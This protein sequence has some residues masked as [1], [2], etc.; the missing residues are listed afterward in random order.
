MGELYYPTP[1]L[2]LTFYVNSPLHYPAGS[3]TS[4]SN[5]SMNVK[6]KT[7]KILVCESGDQVGTSGGKNH[8][9]KIWCYCPFKRKW[10]IEPS[11]KMP[12]YRDFKKYIYC[13]NYV[14]TQISD[15]FHSKTPIYNR[16]RSFVKIFAAF[17]PTRVCMIYGI[18]QQ[19][20]DEH[21]QI[22]TVLFWSCTPSLW[23]FTTY[24]VRV[25]H[26]VPSQPT[27]YRGK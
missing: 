18:M 15:Y 9:P 21:R 4:N 19:I 27:A 24:Y 2:Q 1:T 16:I 25:L 17:L 8:R 26:R 20:D 14:S 11:R 5:N 3:Q 10:W 22:T 13:W 12:H 6:Q 23:L 7:K